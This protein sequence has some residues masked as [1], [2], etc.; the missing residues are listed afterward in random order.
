VDGR[1]PA[2]R[3]GDAL[4]EMERTVKASLFERVLAVLFALDGQVY[5]TPA[6]VRLEVANIRRVRMLLRA[7]FGVGGL[8]SILL[9]LAGTVWLPPLRL[10]AA[11]T[12][13]ATVI[14]IF[15]MLLW[16]PSIRSDESGPP[17]GSEAA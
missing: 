3:A 4:G 17:G 11:V 8:G 14:L 13:S 1:R 2:E 10:L 12:L 15:A 16:L 6:G 9:W 7:L 5:V